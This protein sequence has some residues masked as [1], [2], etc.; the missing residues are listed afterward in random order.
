[1]HRITT[2]HTEIALCVHES[3]EFF[4]GKHLPNIT[5]QC[6]VE[7]LADWQRHGQEEQP[8]VVSTV[9]IMSV[10]QRQSCRGVIVVVRT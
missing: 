1:M 5:A 4:L 8:G 2:K 10:L 6:P 9:G 7:E 3:F